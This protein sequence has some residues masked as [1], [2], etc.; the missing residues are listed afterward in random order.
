MITIYGENFDRKEPY[1]VYFGSEPSS[2]AEVRCGEV[3]ACLP[4]DTSLSI[5]KRRPLLLVRWDGVIFPTST[6]YP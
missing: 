3:M 1:S 4:P 2:F 6:M 5:N